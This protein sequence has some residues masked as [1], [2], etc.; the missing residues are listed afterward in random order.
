MIQRFVIGK[1][2]P[3]ESVVLDLPAETG[4]VPYLTPDGDGWQYVM[5]EKDI[6]YG[7]G[8]MPRGLN[9]RGWHYETNN[10]DESEHGE[11]R[12]SYYAA[13]NFLLISPAD[14]SGCIGV[15]VDF[16]GKVSYD[17]GYTRH[18]TLRFATAEPNYALY[19][20][21]APAAA[22]VA[23][24]FRQLIGPSYIPPKWAFGL[25]QSRFGYKT[26]ADI[27]EV[28]A[29]YKAN[30]LP[31]D[32]IC[33]D[34]DYMQSYADFTI[35]KARFPDL[36]KLAADLKAEG[37]RLVPIIDAGIRCDDNDPV[38]HEGLEKG[39]F[40]TKEDGTPFVAAVWPGKAYFTDFLRPEARAWFGRQY[41]VLTDLGIEGF[42]NDMNEP[43]LFYSPERLKAFFENAA[44]LSRK[45]N[46]DQNDFFGLV[47]SVM[48]LMNAPE[49]YR[50]FYHDT[51][52][53]RVR[54][55]R[56]H[57]LYGG[58]MTRAAGE[59]F[60][61][62]RP[63]Q[64]T[65]LY[66]RSSIIGAHRWGGIWLGDNHS[67]WSQ[68]LANIQMMPAVQMCGFL[69]SGAD[70]CGFS[71]D[72]TP[73]LALRWLEFGLF[74]PLM[75]NHADADAREV[76]DQLLLGEGLMVAPIHTQNAHG[77]TVYLPEGMK[78]LRLR[79]VSDY[80][81]EVLPAGRHYLPCG[82]DEVLLFI[83]PG[84]TVPVA[85]PAANT[86]QLDDT[87][88]TF[89]RFAPDGQPAPY[90]MYTD[91]GVTTDYNRPEHWRIVGQ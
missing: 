74:T 53:G 61:T 87:A 35:D 34:I 71:E 51:A 58:C 9:K 72:T 29:Q 70:L 8:E 26:E 48:G 6:V 30:D 78:M 65:L 41:K 89:W 50:S 85:Q 42:W 39:Y 37:I 20:I 16:P 18:D 5:Q 22:E 57:N 12:L 60:Q 63:G 2:F 15:F 3:T 44:A 77:R 84:H 21:T 69:Y 19:L 17:I 33:M 27:R 82:L 83:R 75:R 25:A 59:A 24:E 47:R 81:E 40:C 67:S 45:D 86:A 66:C 31:L 79:S 56:V 14:G 68:L 49:D 91:D 32:M 54:H 73:D 64:R 28:A 10:T 7:L 90:R 55:D 38:C 76:D 88:L 52:A 46:L 11:N 23:K 80:D 43:A 13:H 62:L 4:P 1:P 36:G